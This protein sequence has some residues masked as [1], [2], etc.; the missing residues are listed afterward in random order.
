MTARA[1][2][3]RKFKRWDEL[4]N[5]GRRYWY[6]V[7]GR[8]GYVARYVKI[9]DANEVTIKFYQEIHDT[10]GKLVSVHEKF[11]ED[12]GHQQVEG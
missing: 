11:P 2:N 5:G 10:R 4:P 12:H 6:D 1:Q 9:V 3:E 8:H 7:S